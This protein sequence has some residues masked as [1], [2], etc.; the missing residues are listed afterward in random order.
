MELRQSVRCLV[1]HERH[2]DGS[3]DVFIHCKQLVDDTEYVRICG[4]GWRG[5]DVAAPRSQQA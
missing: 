2:D 3:D 5:V 4:G 1:K